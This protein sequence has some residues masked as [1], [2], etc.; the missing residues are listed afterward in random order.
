MDANQVTRAINGAPHTH[1]HHHLKTRRWRRWWTVGLTLALGVIGIGAGV[2]FLGGWIP[3]PFESPPPSIAATEPASITTPPLVKVVRPRRNEFAAI[4][5]EQLA[6]VEPYYRAD[7][8]A[9]ASGIVRQVHHDIG[10]K[11]S[12]GDV[13]IEIDVPESDQ[14][15]ARTEAMIVQRAQELKVSQ[16]K[17]KDAIAAKN[18]SA[19]TIKQREADVEGLSASRDLK[20]RKLDRYKDL[21]TRG[22]VVGNVV[23]EEERDYLASEASVKSA[24]ANVERARADY[25]ESESRVEA[26]AADVELKKAQILVAR[27]EYDRAKAVADYAMLR[28]PFDGV[29]VRRTVDPGSFVQNATTGTSESL[30]SI[31]KV[32]IVTISAK[33]PDTVAPSIHEQVPAVVEID[34]LPGLTISAKVSRFAPTVQNADRTM[35]VE[36]D[37]FNGSEDEYQ[38]LLKSVESRDPNRPRKNRNDAIPVRALPPNAPKHKRLLPGMTGTMKLTVGGAGGGGVLPSSAVYSRSGVNYILLVENNR[39][40]QVPVRLFVND[41]KSVS[42]AIVTRRRDAS[43]AMRETLA[44]LNGDEVVVAARQLEIGDGAAIRTSPSDW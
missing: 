7:L 25:A 21:A 31:A 13:L 27:K 9:R 33:F 35:R 28:S 1:H 11:V 22:T 18:V 44:D 23:E 34:D 6:M 36:I 26:A 5:V 19:A 32:D 29:V 17:L 12:K 14:E 10:D 43:G 38:Q 42:L 15:V 20:K 30:I 8:R 40:K 4:V 37:L 16:A 39:T 3:S 41:G 2:G 24:L